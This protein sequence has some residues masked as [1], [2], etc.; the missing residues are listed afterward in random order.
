MIKF[1]MNITRANIKIVI[2]VIIM[3]FNVF[4]LVAVVMPMIS[5]CFKIRAEIIQLEKQAEENDLKIKQ[6]LDLYDDKI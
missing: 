5:N 3:I 4:C 2:A 1:K 6:L